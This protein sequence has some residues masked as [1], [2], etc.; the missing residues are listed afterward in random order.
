MVLACSLWEARELLSLVG[1]KG[2]KQ[3]CTQHLIKSLINLINKV[4]TLLIETCFLQ[5]RLLS[6]I[7]R[8]Q[9]AGTQFE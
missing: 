6:H 5:H 1:E 9:A 4:G 7:K 2:I 8:C 3:V